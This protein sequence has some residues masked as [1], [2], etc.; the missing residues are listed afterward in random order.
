M[1]A[2]SLAHFHEKNEDFLQKEVLADKSA[3]G[4]APQSTS[5]IPFST[6]MYVP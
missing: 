5:V 4:F 2:F 3:G 6:V 1:I